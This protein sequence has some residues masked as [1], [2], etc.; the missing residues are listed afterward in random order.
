VKPVRE[1]G[2][3]VLYFIPWVTVLLRFWI[4]TVP[5]FG[6][7]PIPLALLCA[8][9]VLSA[10]Q[11]AISR[12]Y[13]VLTQSFLLLQSAVITVLILTPPLQ[14][15]YAM[16]FLGLSLVTAKY[17]SAPRDLLWLGFFCLVVSVT[18]VAAWGL[19][20][21]VT[22]FPIYVAGI[23]VLGLYGRTS[24]KAEEA[25]KRSEDLL[26]QLQTAN[27]KLHSYAEQA[28]EVAKIHERNRLARELHDAA[29]QTVFS[30]NLTAEAA[31]MALTQDPGRLPALLEK[32]QES[33]ADALAEMRALVGELRPRNMTEDGLAPTL[34]QHFTIRE[35]RERLRIAF[36]VDGEERGDLDVKEA[37]FRTAQEAL[38]NVVKHA[39]VSEAEVSLKFLDDEITLRI[40]DAGKGF[41]PAASSAGEGFGLASMRERIESRGGS[42][43][44]A[45]RP[46][47]GTEVSA[48]IPLAAKGETHEQEPADQGPDR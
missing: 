28:E 47:A 8:F 39:G 13:P 26:A 32:I 22:Y 27:R 5:E 12:R 46:G 33:S 1:W 2:F 14:D 45:S 20:E 18:L 42:F 48:R 43:A 36:T 31:R 23:L 30:I 37:L 21:G 16:L 17:L 41:D 10:S 4:S 25:R 24:R 29:T 40:R 6:F 9:L 7:F 35:R 15:F 11:P 19:A 44:L 38:N 3:W 34:R